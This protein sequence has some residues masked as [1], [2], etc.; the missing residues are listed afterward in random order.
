VSVTLKT[1][2]VKREK[3]DIEQFWFRLAQQNALFF[4]FLRILSHGKPVS[5]FASKML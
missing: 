2:E 3:G 5:T 1:N 4:L